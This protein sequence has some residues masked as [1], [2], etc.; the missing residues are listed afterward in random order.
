MHVASD[1][2]TPC[3]LHSHALQ[4][5]NGHDEGRPGRR[6]RVVETPNA[7]AELSA[8]RSPVPRPFALRQVAAAAASRPLLAA[9]FGV[10][11]P[12]TIGAILRPR[13]R[14]TSR[15]CRQSHGSFC[16]Q[17]SCATFAQLRDS[18]TAELRRALLAARLRG[19]LHSV[20]QPG[21]CRPRI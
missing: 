6:P 20:L 17:P 16:T 8:A 5:R 3:R 12:L 10:C 11:P 4:R 19:K 21:P 14:G 13:R 9:S 2:C 18:P 15:T 7:K 1:A